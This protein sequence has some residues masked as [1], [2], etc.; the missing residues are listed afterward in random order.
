MSKLIFKTL[1]G[2]RLFGVSTKDSDFDY[3]GI[4]VEDL[5][6]LL[7]KKNEVRQF[8][9]PASATSKKIETE[10]F[11]LN[12][13]MKLLSNGQVIP[14]D[15]LF[16]PKEYWTD[17]SEVWEKIRAVK[18]E[19]VSSRVGPFV[20]YARGQAMKYGLKGNKIVTIEKALKL[21]SMNYSFN[22]ICAELD[23]MEGVVFET[24]RTSNRNIRHIRICG[25][26]FG[27]TTD[28]VLWTVP[29][30]KLRDSFGKRAEEAV[31]GIDLKAQYQT[32][33]ICC[34]AI[35]LLTTG[36]IT[37]PRPEA[38]TLIKI[39]GNEFTPIQLEEMIES[40]FATLQ[41]VE[42]KTTLPAEPNYTRMTDLVYDAQE[43]YLKELYV[44]KP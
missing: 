37:F 30:Q 44:L 36:E 43:S 38:D 1:Y 12:Y 14:M 8:E 3:K 24:E 13:Y 29:L 42:P 22:D 17:S 4:F 28:R 5:S 6:E 27:E 34:E 39:R 31:N 11:S 26:S 40:L 7:E 19:L 33:R 35:E 18:Q 41:E 9:I 15:M 23:G 32:V 2:S 25:K 10:L 20:G 16:T 21:V